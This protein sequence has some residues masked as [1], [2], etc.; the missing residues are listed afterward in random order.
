[1]EVKKGRQKD[2]QSPFKNYKVTKNWHFKNCSLPTV[3]ADITFI[4]QGIKIASHDIIVGNFGVLGLKVPSGITFTYG[5][6]TLKS[7][8]PN[9]LFDW[10]Y[11]NIMYCYRLLR[12]PTT[13][14]II[15][16]HRNHHAYF[17]KC[18]TWCKVYS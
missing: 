8:K 5:T 10:K 2:G 9:F 1:M 16:G 3:S 17:L 11:G 15:F 18:L 12:K 4:N 6:I 7:T 14:A 13:S